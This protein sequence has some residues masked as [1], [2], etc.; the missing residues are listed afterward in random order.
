MERTKPEWVLTLE[1]KHGLPI[2][3]IP[4]TVYVLHV[5]EPTVVVSVS[6][7]YPHEPDPHGGLRSLP[8]RHYVG[9][10]QQADPRR[11]VYRHGRGMS[12]ALAGVTPGTMLDEQAMKNTGRCPT[13]GDPLRPGS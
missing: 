1:A 6:R 5:N 11:R 7:D 10:T 4:G 3:R 13:C 12:Q 8:I 2:E 9:W